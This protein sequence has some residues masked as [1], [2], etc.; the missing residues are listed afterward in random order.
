MKKI[1]LIISV[2]TLLTQTNCAQNAIKGDGNVVTE[3]RQTE[4]YDKITLL[5]SATI[6]LV[7]GTEGNLV[8]SAES[9]I[10]PYVETFVEGNELI[11]RFKDDFNYS[12]KKG[13]KI[14][15]PVQE[16]SEITLKGSGDIIASKTLNI[17][18]LDLNLDGSGD[19]TLNLEAQKIQAKVNGS[20]DIDL[21]GNTIEL[22]GNVNGSGDL[23][24]K[25]LISKN[26]VLIVNGSGDIES[27]TTEKVDAMVVGSGDISVYGNP[28]NVTKNVNG[29][30]NISINK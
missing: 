17:D 1:Y 26:S 15:V 18:N 12:T 4:T 24:A 30:G 3:T 28:T 29:S 2:I 19:I 22:T 23:N 11:V 25:K 8:V 9:N 5:G 20:G 13:I 16:I 6:E 10:V 14:S 27:T 21:K 7:T